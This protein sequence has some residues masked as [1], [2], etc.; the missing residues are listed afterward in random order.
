M[1]KFLGLGISASVLKA[2]DLGEILEQVRLLLFKQGA[3]SL[4]SLVLS[5]RK[6]SNS[7]LSDCVKHTTVR[8]LYACCLN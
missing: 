2:P 8:S 6:R 4:S 7:R 3:Q 1:S 5:L